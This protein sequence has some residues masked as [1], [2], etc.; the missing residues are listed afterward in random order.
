MWVSNV[1]LRLFG[2]LLSLTL[3]QGL[4][5]LIHWYKSLIRMQQRP[6]KIL[7]TTAF[8]IKNRNDERFTFL[9]NNNNNDLHPLTDNHETAVFFG[10]AVVVL[11]EEEQE[12]EPTRDSNSVSLCQGLLW[13][14][15]DAPQTRI[16]L[17]LVELSRLDDDES[18]TNVALVMQTIHDARPEIQE[19]FDRVLTTATLMNSL[20]ETLPSPRNLPHDRR[21][22]QDDNNDDE[23]LVLVHQEVVHHFLS[24]ESGD[25]AVTT[26]FDEDFVSTDSVVPNEE[27][28]QHFSTG[29]SF[30]NDMINS[31]IEDDMIDF[32]VYCYHE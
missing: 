19:L 2:S 23:S 13:S 18:A 28:P 31:M 11:R 24:Q 16:L 25:S 32:E 8:A 15:E 5:D 30:A 29:S 1:L 9:D 20:P 27:Y 21:P 22:F 3:H 17:P 26:T 4:L 14:D 7:V 12:Y 6:H 10:V